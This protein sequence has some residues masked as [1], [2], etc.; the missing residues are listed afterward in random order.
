MEIQNVSV[1]FWSL[2]NFGIFCRKTK[3]QLRSLFD[4]EVSCKLKKSFIT[5]PTD[6]GRRAGVD[7]EPSQE[8]LGQGRRFQLRRAGA[9]FRRR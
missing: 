9:L 3:S 5:S 2:L 8:C 7:V 6:G 4:R 1:A